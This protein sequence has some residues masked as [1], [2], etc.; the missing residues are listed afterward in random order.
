MAFATFLNNRA[1][2]EWVCRAG[3]TYVMETRGWA[4]F[5]N[6]GWVWKTLEV[7]HHLLWITALTSNN[8]WFKI[9]KLGLSYSR[10]NWED[11]HLRKIKS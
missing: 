6:E 8:S 9:L 5:T 11:E 4:K 3:G 2:Q 10:G 7:P 1:G